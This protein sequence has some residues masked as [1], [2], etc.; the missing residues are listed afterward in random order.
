LAKNYKSIPSRYDEKEKAA[1][2][3]YAMVVW[4]IIETVYDRKKVAKTWIP[5]IK[6]EKKLHLKWFE[7]PENYD[8]SKPE[9]RAFVMNFKNY[10]QRFMGVK[11]AI[12]YLVIGFILIS[13]IVVLPIVYSNLMPFVKKER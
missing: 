12:P 4:N 7:E 1:Y 8:K 5:I 9:F 6:A 2:Q 13:V 3:Q 10:D 11:T